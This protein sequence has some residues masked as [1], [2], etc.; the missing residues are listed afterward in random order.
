MVPYFVQD[1]GT[2]KFKGLQHEYNDDFHDGDDVYKQVL[3][4]TACGKANE[5]V[6]LNL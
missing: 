1:Y 4:P 5:Q 3:N 6:L 2:L